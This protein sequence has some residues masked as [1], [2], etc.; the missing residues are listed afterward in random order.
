MK[1]KGIVCLQL[2]VVLLLVGCSPLRTSVSKGPS[3]LFETFYLGGK[4]TQYFV[5]P[6]IFEDKEDNE[7]SVDFTFVYNDKIQAEDSVTLNFSVFLP[8]VDR[9]DNL[10]LQIDNDKKT[11]AQITKLFKDALQTRFSTRVL[12]S[13][14]KRFFE[15]EHKSII[16][17]REY[18]PKK[19]T[20]KKLQKVSKG[21]FVSF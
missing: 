8:N 17:E 2:L 4:G 11:S 14:V 10:T 12:L 6:L 18:F 1:N 19:S 5:K 16:L 7:I 21:I 13:D 15:A 9:A 3:K 20:A